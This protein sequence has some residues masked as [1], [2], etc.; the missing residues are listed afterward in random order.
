ML[1]ELDSQCIQMCLQCMNH[2]D[3]CSANLVERTQLLITILTF[4][5]ET[6]FLSQILL[7]DFR[8]FSGYKLIADVAIRLEKDNKDESRQEMKNLFYCLEEFSSAGHN[9]LKM[10]NSNISM[11]KIEGFEI[12]QPSGKGRTVRNPQTFQT[13]LNIFNRVNL[14]LKNAP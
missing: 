4:L 13:L 6:S 14:K 5:R 8:V 2:G 12:P 9:E 10:N 11:F 7:E 1:L 3:I